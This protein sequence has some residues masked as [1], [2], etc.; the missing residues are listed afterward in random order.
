MGLEVAALAVTAIGAGISAYSAYQSNQAQASSAS[1]QSQVAANNAK[2]ATI[3]ATNARRDAALAYQQQTAQIETTAR[4]GRAMVGS[5]ITGAASHGLLVDTGSAADL[6]SDTARLLAD[7][8]GRQTQAGDRAN[9]RGMI[10]A[11]NYETQS[12]MLGAQSEL[13]DNLSDAAA[14]NWLSV[15]GGGLSGAR[16][17]YGLYNDMSNVGLFSDMRA[18]G[19]PFNGNQNPVT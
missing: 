13:Y 15:V 10:Q 6:T 18:S 9:A 19:Q 17:G 1:Y 8:V 7:D 5:Q 11:F 16:A 12:G 4:R 2:L 3:N 14:G